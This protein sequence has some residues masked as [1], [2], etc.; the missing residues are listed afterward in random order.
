ME[1]KIYQ[2]TWVFGFRF[3][4]QFTIVERIVTENPRTYYFKSKN[5]RS[6]PKKDLR[7]IMHYPGGAYF[8]YSTSKEDLLY[9]KQEMIKHYEQQINRLNW[10]KE[11]MESVLEEDEYTFHEGK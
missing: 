3:H 4:P 2:Y 6:L 9:F 7:K 11:R 5:A 8:M 10:E 1:T